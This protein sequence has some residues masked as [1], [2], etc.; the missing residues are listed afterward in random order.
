M[1]RKMVFE[2]NSN[3]ETINNVLS[4][5]L[6]KEGLP[7]DHKVSLRVDRTT[8]M[9]LPFLV[10]EW[11]PADKDRGKPHIVIGVPIISKLMRGQDVVLESAVLMPDSQL[12]NEASKARS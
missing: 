6:S 12:M 8:T 4:E 3:L 1:M 10:A 11:V 9:N 2:N 5:T 7:L